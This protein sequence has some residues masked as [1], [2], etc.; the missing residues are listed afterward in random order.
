[1]LDAFAS[2]EPVLK[3]CEPGFSFFFELIRKECNG[4]G[5]RPLHR[6]C[7]LMRKMGVRSFVREDL[8]KNPELLGEQSDASIRTRGPAHLKAV[9]L[10]FFRDCPANN[11]WRDVAADSILGYAVVATLTLPDKTARVY[12]LESVVCP[13][14]L[15]L[16]DGNGGLKPEMV[17]NY[18]LHCRREFVTQVGTKGDTRIFELVGSF[19]CQQNDLTHV[20]AHAA[21]RIAVN[22]S[23][24]FSG[25]KLMNSTINTL[26]NL[27]H[28][29]D[30]IV[31]R[32]PAPGPSLGVHVPGMVSVVEQLGW[33]AHVGDFIQ[34][35]AVDY[36]EFIYPIIESGCPTILGVQNYQSAHV[37]AVLGHTLNTD[38]WSP[39]ARQGYGSFPHSPFIP[40][41]AWTDHFIVSDDNFGMYVTV[42]T[43]SIRNLLIP[44]YNPNL[45]ASVAIGLMPGSVTLNGYRTERLAAF[46]A[47]KLVSFAKAA[48]G[49]RWLA[50]L[51]GPGERL[52]C[53]TFLCDKARYLAHVKAIEDDQKKKLGA[54]EIT[55]LEAALPDA[56]WTT[57]I[58]VPN[59]Y[60]GNKRKVGDLLSRVD[61]S[62]VDFGAGKLAFFGWLP[63][64]S[65]PQGLL[66][67]PADWPIFGHVP[68]LRGASETRQLLEW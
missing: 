64:V 67:P 59:L 66:Q 51:S 12:I 56:F 41:S 49:N 26:L 31:G 40:T 50:L 4:E 18:Y 32:Y 9:R 7:T 27:T 6:I 21:L 15:W 8:E 45:H 14:S 52:V 33:R 38:R 10:T 16:G 28:T 55:N 29:G 36:D 60:C 34:N 42:P 35:P 25:S 53:R 44:K 39:E 54:A 65:W 46:L 43:D 5:S 2:A 68:V 3:N 17:S 11:S 22:S 37:F 19:F 24:A 58:T 61:G 30:H 63:G 47:A 48:P 20:C 13:P 57:E 23:P 62:E 1:M